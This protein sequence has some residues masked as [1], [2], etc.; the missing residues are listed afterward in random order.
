MVNESE[1]LQVAKDAAAREGWPWAEPVVIRRHRA[2]LFFGQV[3][4][5]VMTNAN[6]R[7]QNVNIH[8]DDRTATVTTK[9]FAPR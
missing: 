6:Y 7:G 2:W 8:I 9:A 4:W 5:H 3:R 1:V